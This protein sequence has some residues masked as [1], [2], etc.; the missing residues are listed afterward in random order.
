MC[1]LA[2]SSGCNSKPTSKEENTPK[3]ESEENISTVKSADGNSIFYDTRGEGD[4][5]IV[6]VHCWTCN[7]D[8]WQPQIEYFS[9]N[10]QV[11]RLDLAGHG[12]SESKRQQYTMAAFGKD[13][14]AVVNEV[15]TDKVVLVGHSMGGPVVIEAAKLL[16]DRV[17]GIVGVDVFYT[18]FAY[19]TS[20]TEIEAFVQPFKD[21][22]SSASEEL[23]RSMF[24]PAADPQLIESTIKQMG[25]ANP[26]MAVNAM[27]EIFTWNA[28]QGEADLEE[29]SSKI[30][31]IN[32]AP[33]GQENALHE[34]VTLIPGV[35][36]FVAQAKPN[37]FNQILEQ[38]ITKF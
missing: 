15:A 27:T 5:T 16:G 28:Q 34:S 30:R 6:F 32:G 21:D 9:Q 17:V 35:G 29:Y 3:V 24:T 23:V 13:V 19:P 18:P 7:S 2:F 10:Y 20:E 31:N 22:F 25:S 14:A 38:I 36:H 1:F 4:T 11:V 8:F 33:T 12:K 26:E 37:E